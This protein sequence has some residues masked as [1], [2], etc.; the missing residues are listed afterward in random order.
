MPPTWT[1]MDQDDEVCTFFRTPLFSCP[2]T[3]TERGL[4]IPHDRA[5]FFRTSWKSPT[6]AMC[7]SSLRFYLSPRWAHAAHLPATQEGSLRSEVGFATHLDA[8]IDTSGSLGDT[9]N[10]GS[11]QRCFSV[12]KFRGTPLP[13]YGRTMELPWMMAVWLV[14]VR[15]MHIGASHLCA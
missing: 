5:M 6:A 1:Y 8:W 10:I 7:W 12:N 4:A 2:S 11:P 13:R 9:F 3:V 14:T 15:P